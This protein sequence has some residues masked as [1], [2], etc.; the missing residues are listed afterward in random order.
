MLFHWMPVIVYK[1]AIVGIPISEVITSTWTTV[2]QF[3][4]TSKYWENIYII[5][6]VILYNAFK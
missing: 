1:R 5:W 6:H 2:L 3:Y 4:T